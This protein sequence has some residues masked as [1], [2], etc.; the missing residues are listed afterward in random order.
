MANQVCF[1]VLRNNFSPVGAQT[2]IHSCTLSSCVS[3]HGDTLYDLEATPINNLLGELLEL[4]SKRR[5][6]E[7]FLSD[8]LYG[9]GGTKSVWTPPNTATDHDDTV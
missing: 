8:I 5:K 2:P 9:V 1:L 3:M 6:L 7:V 4:G